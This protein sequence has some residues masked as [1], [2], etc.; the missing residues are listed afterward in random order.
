MFAVISAVATDASKPEHEPAE[1]WD[2]FEEEA[3]D[4]YEVVLAPPPP[5]AAASDHLVAEAPTRRD[6]KR[7]LRD[8]NA[9]AARELCGH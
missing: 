2:G 1:E 7:R 5:L 4:H 6:E 8:A 9:A 3:A